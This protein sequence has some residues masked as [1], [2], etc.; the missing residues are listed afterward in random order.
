[1]P[2]TPLLSHFNV[3]DEELPLPSWRHHN[4]CQVEVRRAKLAQKGRALW[5]ETSCEECGEAVRKIDIRFHRTYECKVRMVTCR[6]LGCGVKYRADLQAEHE[7]ECEPFLRRKA[8]LE[9]HEQQ[10][11]PLPC[12]LCGQQIVA[13]QLDAHTSSQC[14]HRLVEC[15]EGCGEKIPFHRLQAHR[16]FCTAPHLV[17]R[18]ELVIRS[19]R[20]RGDFERPWSRS[21]GRRSQHAVDSTHQG[22]NEHDDDDDD[23]DKHNNNHAAAEAA[24]S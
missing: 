6:H 15:A 5:Q 7:Q 16:N 11:Q 8:L 17:Y 1:M 9:S 22:S 19:R 20:R 14:V 2:L 12:N 4:L 18:R 21:A 23:D 3:T 10:S 24:V 13:R